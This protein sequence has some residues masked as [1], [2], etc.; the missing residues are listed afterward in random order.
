[1]SG[2]ELGAGQPAWQLSLKAEPHLRGLS[3][4]QQPRSQLAHWQFVLRR[5]LRGWLAAQWRPLLLF[6]R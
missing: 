1:M 6:F 4:G 2:W 5:S 3:A